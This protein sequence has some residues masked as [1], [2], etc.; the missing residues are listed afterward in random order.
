MGPHIFSF[1]DTF[2]RNKTRQNPESEIPVKAICFCSMTQNIDFGFKKPLVLDSLSQFLF[3]LACCYQGQ[4]LPDFRSPFLD[5]IP[6]F[7][8]L[9]CKCLSTSRY[10]ARSLNFQLTLAVQRFSSTSENVPTGF[11][12][13]PVLF[14]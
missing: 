6:P 2:L 14:F 11:L 8:C 13:C 9:L 7:A 3:G 10:A 1:W 12:Y 4:H 5:L